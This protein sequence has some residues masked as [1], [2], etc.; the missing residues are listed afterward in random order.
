MSILSVFLSTM[1]K[2]TATEFST[3]ATLQNPSQHKDKFN[4]FPLFIIYY[5]LFSINW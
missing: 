3:R 5:L 1:L 2:M 4:N